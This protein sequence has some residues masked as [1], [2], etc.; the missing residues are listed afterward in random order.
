VPP[1]PPQ[2]PAQI[3]RIALRPRVGMR[4]YM[5]RAEGVA[6]DEA[7]TGDGPPGPPQSP[8]S[9]EPAPAPLPPRGGAMQ[10]SAVRRV[11]YRIR[12]YRGRP[13]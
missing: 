6:M 11:Q 8:G 3:V 12:T 7:V 5:T 2:A 10:D 9:E 4:T 1:V 13:G